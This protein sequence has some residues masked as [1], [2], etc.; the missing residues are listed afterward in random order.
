MFS[1]LTLL[2]SWAQSVSPA[3]DVCRAIVSNARKAEQQRHNCHFLIGAK[4][5]RS[6][7]AHLVHCYDGELFVFELTRDQAAREKMLGRVMQFVVDGP[8]PSAD[9][10]AAIHLEHLDIDQADDLPPTSPITGRCRCVVDAPRL[11]GVCLCLE[12]ALRTSRQQPRKRRDSLYFYPPALVAGDATIPFQF[13]AVRSPDDSIPPAPGQVA[14]GFLRFCTAP[15]PKRPDGGVP[16]SNAL[17]AL[18][19]FR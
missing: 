8:R 19:T 6:G 13:A 7:R 18:L 9:A 12:M 2:S 14:A 11:D 1:L 16:L 3:G 17:G 4:L 10:P 15:D 5:T